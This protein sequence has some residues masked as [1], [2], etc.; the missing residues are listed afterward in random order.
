MAT[1][2][3][4]SATAA[5]ALGQ[6]SAPRVRSIEILGTPRDFHSTLP[7]VEPTGRTTPYEA[8]WGG[9]MSGSAATRE[10]AAGDAIG[11]AGTNAADTVATGA[12]GEAAVQDWQPHAISVPAL[13][14]TAWIDG[15]PESALPLADAS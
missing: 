4:L 12:V 9:G 3:C 14:G 1:G 6:P 8:S 2:G 7:A 5:R 11:A 10:C 13:A 15:A